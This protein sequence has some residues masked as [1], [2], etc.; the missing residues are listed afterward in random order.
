MW[1]CASCGNERIYCET[2]TEPDNVNAAFYLLCRN[3]K[4]GN[5]P[6]LGGWRWK[7]YRLHIWKR[8]MRLTVPLPGVLRREMAEV[9][10]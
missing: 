4:C 10:A 3:P 2:E 5:A 6:W 9:A 8:D 7:H 1:A